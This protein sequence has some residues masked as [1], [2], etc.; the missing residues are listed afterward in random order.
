MAFTMSSFLS[1][2]FFHFSSRRPSSLR[3][4]SKSNYTVSGSGTT[5]NLLTADD[6]GMNCESGCMYYIA[7]VA[8]TFVAEDPPPVFEISVQTSGKLNFVPCLAYAPD[9]IRFFT[10]GGNRQQHGPVAH[11]YYAV[12]A[13]KHPP[14]NAS[15]LAV[16]YEQCSGESSLYISDTDSNSR[17]SPH[18]ALLPNAT[19][20]G[21]R[22]T[23]NSTCSRKWSSQTLRWGQTQCADGPSAALLLLNRSNSDNY[24]L[25]AAG[26]G[27]Y[28]VTVQDG[29]APPVQVVVDDKYRGGLGLKGRPWVSSSVRHPVLLDDSV[30]IQWDN[31]ITFNQ[32][33]KP[34][35]ANLSYSIYMIDLDMAKA[36]KTVS[37]QNIHLDTLCGLQW[38]ENHYH[39]G[40]VK[41]RT[42]HVEDD[43]PSKGQPALR[44]T[45]DLGP[46]PV[47][48]TIY[49]TVVATCDQSC[50]RWLS[51]T[52]CGQGSVCQT[53]SV[54][55]S[56]L[57]IVS[58][59]SPS[60]N[61]PVFGQ[62]LIF[63]FWVAVTALLFMLVVGVKLMHDR[64]IFADLLRR[65][66]REPASLS[67]PYAD[68]LGDESGGWFRRWGGYAQLSFTEMVDTSTFG[69]PQRSGT[70]PNS[71]SG[72]EVGVPQPSRRD[73][74]I[75]QGPRL[76]GTLADGLSVAA[77]GVASLSR[78]VGIALSDTASAALSRYS[79]G[80]R[81][82][83]SD[84][85][86]ERDI[87]RSTHP[88]TTSSYRPPSPVPL[89]SKSTPAS[90]SAQ[91]SSA[92][93]AM[94]TIYPNAVA[95]DSRDPSEY[96]SFPSIG[97][98]TI[99]S[100]SSRGARTTAIRDDEEDSEETL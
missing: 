50:M 86:G 74:L 76:M 24:Y 66:P 92:F 19:F 2:S 10:G 36:Q 25:L 69:A 51:H 56:P 47:G 79:T 44:L 68:S 73:I 89:A 15:V 80:A 55:Y 96:S 71:S 17:G 23:G 8:Q 14:S 61:R 91:E 9:G 87:D 35:A 32:L 82:E 30:V 78:T 53:Q 57:V 40:V 20:W 5:S 99:A 37:D 26:V 59:A 12:C 27:E 93:I 4:Q 77:A 54:V 6:L 22:L 34:I 81:R 94:T 7:V 21:H 48:H 43:V 29:K 38:A 84:R 62:L 58:A 49:I 11:T 31:A 88:L 70:R 65:S 3:G 33:R 100:S 45:S 39:L 97:Q 64:G 42:Y 98:P 52:P 63:T 83:G 28:K 18:Q 16:T 72:Y 41:V 95:L 85:G 1:I 90:S 75:G 13:R 46:M 60:D 67:T